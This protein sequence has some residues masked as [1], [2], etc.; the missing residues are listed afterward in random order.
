MTEAGFGYV[1]KSW[2]EEDCDRS[3]LD[4]QSAALLRDAGIDIGKTV[5]PSSAAGQACRYTLA[6]WKKL[7]RFLDYPELELSSN[8]AENS[9]RPIVL[10]RGNWTHIGSE[11]AGP[12][13]AAIHSAIES[14]RRIEVP[15]RDYLA[16]ILPRLANAPLQ[17]IPELTP[18]VWAAKTSSMHLV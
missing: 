7:I 1:R 13:V 3:P 18:A 2:T 12:R 15:V 5:L 11:P 6:I 9:M 4:R 8:L 17:Q 10:G 16:D 14:C